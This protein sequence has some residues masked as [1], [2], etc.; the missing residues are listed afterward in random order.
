MSMCP[1]IVIIVV[2]LNTWGG[3]GVGRES[4]IV[5]DVRIGVAVAVAVACPTSTVV[6]AIFLLIIIDGVCHPSTVN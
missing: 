2:Q 4:C 5:V 1:A 6:V 3:A